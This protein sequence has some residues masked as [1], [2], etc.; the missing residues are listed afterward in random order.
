METNLDNNNVTLFLK[1]KDHITQNI[2][3]NKTILGKPKGSLEVSRSIK[4]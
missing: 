2:T 1:K 3:K 4:G